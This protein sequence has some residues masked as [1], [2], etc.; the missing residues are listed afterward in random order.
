MR[1]G[2]TDAWDRYAERQAGATI[3]HTSAWKS[4]MEEGLGHQPYPL[5]AVAAN[6]EYAG[7]LP[8]FLVRGIF[9]RRLV[10]VPM[11]DR[12]G[13][14]ADDPETASSLVRSALELSRDLRC[15]YL[16]L[17][18]LGAL[19]EAVVNEH[20]LRC[21]RYWMTTRVDLSPGPAML[22]K[23]LDK[24][25]I[26][27]SIK[28]ARRNQIRVA[29]DTSADGML[30]FHDLFV[31]TRTHMG[32]PPYPRS[33]FMAI[34]EHLVQTEK[35]VLFTIWNGSIPIH[36]MISLLSGDTF[37]PAYAAPQ[38]FWRKLY[39]SEVMIW[40]TI[41]WACQRAFRV[42]DFGADS[43]EQSGLLWFKKKWGGV[44]HRMHYYFRLSGTSGP[45][46]LDSSRG[47]HALVRQAW[48][49]LPLGASAM[50][51]G[52]VTRQLS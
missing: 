40:H 33:L 7:I 20:G 50:L 49:R 45:P 37:I 39:P 47:A 42:Y 16:E 18:S 3:Y 13:L 30:L 44:P 15:K 21:E 32:I 43:P 46:N 12:G 24:D 29:E 41:E 27:W 9:G 1:P 5:R 48:S 36:S 6:G 35:A 8:L 10:S 25:A 23:R 19:D 31:A 17:R 34:W 2:E 26:R 51:G 14:I 38:N 22:W 28:K 11:R 52:W 4:V